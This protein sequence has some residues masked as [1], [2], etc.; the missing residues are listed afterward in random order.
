[1]VNLNN[2]TG[3]LSRKRQR[4]SHIIFMHGK[5]FGNNVWEDFVN[6]IQGAPVQQWLKQL[7]ELNKF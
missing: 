4:T 2:H 5:M 6:K 3:K 7:G 1:M